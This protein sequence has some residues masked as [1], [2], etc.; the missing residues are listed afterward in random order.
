MKD[1]PKTLGK[2]TVKD[3]CNAGAMTKDDEIVFWVCIGI[4][5]LTVFG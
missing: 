4:C 5:V 2:T 1:T 3:P